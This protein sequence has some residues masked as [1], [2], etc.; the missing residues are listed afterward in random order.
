MPRDARSLMKQSDTTYRGG[1]F[2]PSG[3]G[4]RIRGPKPPHGIPDYTY[5][6]ASQ[7]IDENSTAITVINSAAETTVATLVVPALT[8]RSQGA[9][10]LAA[11]GTVTNTTDTGG[12][13]TFKVVASVTGS[14]ATVLATT[15]VS[16]STS[17]NARKWTLDE[18]MFGNDTNVQTHW[19]HFDLSAAST[20]TLP[21]STFS[22]VGSSDGALDE[23][24]QITL[25]VT[26][27]MSVGS[28]GFSVVR[29]SA[30]LEAIL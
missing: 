14:T 5:P 26:A 18:I 16:C 12:G 29:E 10:R 4:K 28:T 17:A 20:G 3:P 8:V 27:Q 19:G 22:G 11:S 24:E 21:P 30:I 13:V 6:V 7:K 2:F 1:S 15:A 9:T 23:T 25:K